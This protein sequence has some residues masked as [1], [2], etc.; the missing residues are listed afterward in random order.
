MFKNF[1][2]SGNDAKQKHRL[3]YPK[4]AY[5]SDRLSAASYDKDFIIILGCMI[6]PDETLRITVSVHSRLICFSMKS[7]IGS[8]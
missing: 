6:K 4:N 2:F 7:V 5:Q 3:C 8:A 1:I